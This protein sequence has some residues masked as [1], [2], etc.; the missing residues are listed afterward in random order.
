MGH[1]PGKLPLAD[2]CSFINSKRALISRDHM[3]VTLDEDRNC[4]ERVDKSV[5]ESLD[6]V[7]LYSKW[8]VN[9]LLGLT[10]AFLSLGVSY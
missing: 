6:D 10:N 8:T 2:D 4:M 9:V 3:D 7:G 5:G 1:G